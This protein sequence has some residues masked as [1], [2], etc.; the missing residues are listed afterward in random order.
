MQNFK[1]KN[2]FYI[3]RANKDGLQAIC[4]DCSILNSKLRKQKF[5]KN[6]IKQTPEELK[7][8]K[9][10][11]DKLWRQNNPDK[12]RARRSRYERRVRLA[13]PKWLTLEQWA[14]IDEIYKNCPEGY[15]VDHIKVDAL[16]VGNPGGC[17]E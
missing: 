8:K 13:T 16:M 4:S 2:K 17:P 9:K 11:Y 7:L 10:A 5:K 14:Q 15:H 3:C 1:F 6:R 12:A